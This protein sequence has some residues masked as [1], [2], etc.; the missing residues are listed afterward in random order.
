MTNLKATKCQSL[1]KPSIIKFS[2]YPSSL[3]NSGNFVKTLKIRVKLIPQAHVITYTYHFCFWFKRKS[4]Q[5]INEGEK[6]N[7]L[8]SFVN[9]EKSSQQCINE[10]NNSLHIKL[11]VISGV[12]VNLKWGRGLCYSYTG[13]RIKIATTSRLVTFNVNNEK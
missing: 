5:Y 13:L 1:T 4:W 8:S 7:F 6:G 9:I 2:K 12:C 3:R 10:N 11:N